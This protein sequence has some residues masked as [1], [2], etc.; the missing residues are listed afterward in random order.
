MSQDLVNELFQVQ[1]R[2]FQNFIEI[3]IPDGWKGTLYIFKCS[4]YTILNAYII[5][6]TK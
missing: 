2:A 1:A 6:N 5:R 4:N 3:E